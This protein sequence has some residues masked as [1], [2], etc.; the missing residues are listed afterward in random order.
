MSTTTLSIPSA[1]VG[2]PQLAD[3]AISDATH[4]GPVS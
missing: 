3:H 1:F 4:M 2:S